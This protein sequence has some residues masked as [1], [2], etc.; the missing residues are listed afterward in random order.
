VQ[1]SAL[2]ELSNRLRN[3]KLSRGGVES[4]ARLV[5]GRQADPSGPWSA[6][7][8][9]FVEDSRAAGLL[10]AEQWE[11][12][13]LQG[14]PAEL[15]PPGRVRRGA[16]FPVKVRVGPARLGS[17]LQVHVEFHEPAVEVAGRAVD[18]ASLDR[19]SSFLLRDA[20]AMADGKLTVYDWAQLP[21]TVPKGVQPVRFGVDLR[22]RHEG[23]A[24]EG[25]TRSEPVRRVEW[26]GK[27][28][29]HSSE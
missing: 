2:A 12:Y 22:L 5:L 15:Q 20:P 8:G 7:F 10:G 1:Q 29:L 17:V 4:A 9:D 13:L 14:V 6:G 27:I 3:G 23:D 25:E 26:A 11:R 16:V 18:R 21:A 24:E 19:I 28:E